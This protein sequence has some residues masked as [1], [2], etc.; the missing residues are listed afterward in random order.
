MAY[1]RIVEATRHSSTMQMHSLRASHDS[2]SREGS[3]LSSRSPMPLKSSAR[4][5]PRP[6]TPDSV[7]SSPPTVHLMPPPPGNALSNSSSNTLTSP[8]V[9]VYTSENHP[10]DLEYFEHPLLGSA[11]VGMCMCPGR[12]KPKKYHVWKRDL[13][14]DLQAIASSGCD[15]VVTLV[16]SVEL[17]S[18]GI[19]E[20]F[21]RIKQLGMESLHFPVVDKW[22]PESMTSVME[23]I[24]KLLAYVDQGKTIVIHWFGVCL[25]SVF[26]GLTFFFHQ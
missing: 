11:K 4:K 6:A 16:R 12:N 24:S 25:F 20:L 9:K 13:Q 15:V 17:L 26:A 7:S 19:I 10:L 8:Q 21:V 22:I 3:T 1:Q 5:S 18:M 2:L 23:L 14:T